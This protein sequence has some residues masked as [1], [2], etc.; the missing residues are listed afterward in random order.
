M[1]I[2]N[3][4]Y[5][6]PVLSLDD[7]DYINGSTFYVEYTLAEATSFKP[8][9]LTAKFVL[10][11]EQ[12]ERM[13]KTGVAGFFVHA[14]SPR[15]AYRHLFE[16]DEKSCTFELVIDAKTMRQK[17]EVTSFI[18]LKQD[19]TGYQNKN[20]NPELYGVNYIGPNLSTG[21]PLAVAFTEEI[22]ISEVNDFRSV[23]SIMK[24][25]KTNEK[26]MNVDIESDSIYVRL[27][28][29]QYMNYVRFG[30][31]S[32]AETMLSSIIFPS[33][34]YALDAIANNSSEIYSS[35]KWY[36]VI[37]KKIDSLNYSIAQL[38]SQDISSVVLAQA[39]LENPLERTLIEIGEV[40]SDND[41][42]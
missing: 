12:L 15:S 16:V 30:T 37:E 41:E 34:I 7:E 23:S 21:D 35:Q 1:R 38:K 4:L 18:I 40:V 22:E 13:I 26:L 36:Q 20:I 19:L 14:E 6:Y 10:E 11:D 5:P 17:L 8:A 39:I 32:L 25:G 42:D 28:E 27:P 9:V 3:S 31:S 29:K 24:V 2:F 33:L